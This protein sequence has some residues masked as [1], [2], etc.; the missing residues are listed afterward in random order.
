M[1]SEL[2]QRFSIR[3][4]LFASGSLQEKLW[5]EATA[6]R[7][8]HFGSEV[9]IRGVLEISNFC[10]QNCDYC[11]MRREN[12]ELER[13]RLDSSTAWDHFTSTVPAS[14]CDINFQTGEDVVGI[15]ETVLPLI[16]RIRH[17]TRY[18]VSLCLGTLD[19]QIYDELRSAG[20]EF[21]IMKI[22]SGNATHFQQIHAPGTLKK[23]V[24]SIQYLAQ[25]GWYVS[26]GYISGLP[27]QTVEH[28]L[29]TLELLRSLPLTGN[30]VSPF[31]PGENTPFAQGEM[32]TGVEA[33]NS[34]AV[35]RLLAP[36]RII[37]A[38]S[39]FNITDEKGYTNALRAGANLATINLTPERQRDEYQLYTKKRVIMSEERVLKSIH[40]AGL[41]PSR[42]SM[43]AFLN[44]R[45]Q[46]AG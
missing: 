1:V 2:L 25:S 31:V 41:K 46:P 18:G 30:S 8:F 12:R 44:A 19:F 14:V 34:I 20:A 40:Q 26:S 32:M 4:L 3:D 43:I 5:Q 17:E 45:K 33:L 27:F 7:E 24:E 38:V 42:Q 21:Y 36:E 35:M 6:L 23:R 15:R 9:F 28:V 37:P 22:E 39:A 13:Y 29:E 16:R 10:R 11:G